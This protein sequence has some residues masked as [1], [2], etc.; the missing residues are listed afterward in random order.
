MRALLLVLLAFGAAYACTAADRQRARS[1]LDSAADDL[2][3]AC[4]ARAA[5]KDAGTGDQ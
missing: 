1:T 5:M 4:A 3:R 2:D